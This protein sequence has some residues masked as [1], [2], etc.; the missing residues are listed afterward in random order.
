MSVVIT[1]PRRTDAAE[2]YVPFSARADVAG[3]IPTVREGE[4]W[5]LTEPARSRSAV[6]CEPFRG[7]VLSANLRIV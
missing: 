7:G 5:K 4:G 2:I 6:D 1:S 3:V